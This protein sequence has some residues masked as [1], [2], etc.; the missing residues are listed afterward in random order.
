M[1]LENNNL[2][3]G[4]GGSVVGGEIVIGQTPQHSPGGKIGLSHGG[5]RQRTTLQ[6]EVKYNKIEKIISL[7]NTLSTSRA[8][9]IWSRRDWI[10]TRGG[11]TVLGVA[12][13]ICGKQASHT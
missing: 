4:V 13:W 3:G 8:A 12:R 7:Q 10:G 1:C 6:S 2:L 9:L 5:L 11:R